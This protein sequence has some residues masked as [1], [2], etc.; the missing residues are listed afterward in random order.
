MDRDADDSTP[1]KSQRK[2]EAQELQALAVSLVDLPDAQLQRIPLPE[3]LRDAIV[4]TRRITA[5]GAL[6]R[7]HQYLGRLMR[8]ADAAPVRDAI[9]AL[10]RESAGQTRHFHALEH[11]RDRLIDEGDGALDDLLA[12]H[13]TLQRAP[14][15]HL[16]RQA[17]REVATDAPKRAARSLFRHLREH[18]PPDDRSGG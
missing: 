13:P 17:Q 16:I 9:A 3:R 2:R 10:E 15:R 4:E 6:R 11:W 7:Q 1:S 14:L 18:V 8:Q 12:A 5:H